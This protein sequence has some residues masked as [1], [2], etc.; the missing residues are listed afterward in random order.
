MQQQSLS[1]PTLALAQN[2][3]I[4]AKFERQLPQSSTRQS[5]LTSIEFAAL[6]EEEIHWQLQREYYH[7]RYL[8]ADQL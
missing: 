5:E 3:E 7:D 8:Y 6:A 2:K 1:L 4:S